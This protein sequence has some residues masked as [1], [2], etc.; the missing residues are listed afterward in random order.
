MLAWKASIAPTT[1][2]RTEHRCLGAT[3]ALEPEGTG[4][5]EP[6]H[7]TLVELHHTS[8]LG[9]FD[10]ISWR[11]AGE[12]LLVTQRRSEEVTIGDDA[13]QVESLKSERKGARRFETR[14]CVRDDLREQRVEVDGDN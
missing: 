4:S 14:R 3:L 12:E 2:H 8:G 6:C 5:R 11:V 13:A 7:F 9:S 1:R 10:E